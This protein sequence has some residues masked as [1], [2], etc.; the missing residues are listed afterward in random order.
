MVMINQKDITDRWPTV[1]MAVVIA[2]GYETEY[3]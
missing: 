1:V 3:Y 2:T